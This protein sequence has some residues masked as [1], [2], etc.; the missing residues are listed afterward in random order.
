MQHVFQS[1]FRAG[2]DLD[3]RSRVAMPRKW[4]V[5]REMLARD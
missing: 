4:A 3:K 5:L 2:S 1:R